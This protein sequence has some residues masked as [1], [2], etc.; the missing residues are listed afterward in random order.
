M[1]PPTLLTG[2]ECL[3]DEAVRRGGGDGDGDGW[4]WRLWERLCVVVWCDCVLSNKGQDGIVV[5]VDPLSVKVRGP[6]Q[7]RDQELYSC[8]A[9]IR[10]ILVFT[11]FFLNA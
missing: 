11:L 1:W 7:P 5:G 4:G 3:K 8:S 10:S 2:P 9:V 6:D